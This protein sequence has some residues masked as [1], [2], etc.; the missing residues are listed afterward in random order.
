M[1]KMVEKHCINANDVFVFPYLI[2]F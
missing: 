2:T 1:L